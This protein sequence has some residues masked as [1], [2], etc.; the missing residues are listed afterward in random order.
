MLLI[1]VTFKESGFCLTR[2]QVDSV[3]QLLHQQGA[4]HPIEELLGNDL[5][6]CTQWGVCSL[7]VS[8]VFTVLTETNALF[9][10]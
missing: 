5:C 7:W 4:R 6:L 2:W 10:S 8:K 1:F 9:Y 3:G